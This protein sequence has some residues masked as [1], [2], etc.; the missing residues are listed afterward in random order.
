M[1]LPTL[2]DE[3]RMGQIPAKHLAGGC[4]YDSSELMV[5]NHTGRYEEEYC[6]RHLVTLVQFWAC[7]C[8]LPLLREDNVAEQE[9]MSSVLGRCKY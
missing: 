1:D 7:H 3:C 8:L 6:R 4:Q 5:V 9:E 2:H